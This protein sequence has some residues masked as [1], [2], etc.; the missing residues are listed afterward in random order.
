MSLSSKPN[1]NNKSR[2][3]ESEWD[4]TVVIIATGLAKAIKVF[5][6][7]SILFPMISFPILMSLWLWLIAGPIFG[8]VLAAI[9]GLALAAWSLAR[10][11]RG[12]L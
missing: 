6:W 2:S 12:L 7:W 1:G 5:V 8:I 11:F 3:T 10:I 9:S 4:H